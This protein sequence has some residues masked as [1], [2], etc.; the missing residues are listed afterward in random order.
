MLTK[1]QINLLIFLFFIF[2]GFR[3]L[4]LGM[5]PLMD[6][7]ESRY[8]EISREMVTQN[9]WITPLL[10]GKPFWA[11]PPLS[12]WAVNVS[13]KI[14]GINEFGA[15]F[16]S[17]V[18]CLFVLFFTYF[19]TYKITNKN[20]IIAFIS[21]F[22]LLTTTIF[23]VVSGGVMTDASLLFSVSLALVSFLLLIVTEKKIWNYPFF[24]GV[25]LS[26]LAKGPLGLVLIF[27]P[28][29]VWLLVFNEWK[30][31]FKKLYFFQ[32][33]F[34]VSITAIPWYILAEKNTPGFLNY[35]LLGEHVY[36]YIFK[37]W[38]GDLYGS[39]AGKHL[40]MI[41]LYAL[42]TF[43]PWI[44]W[45]SK[46]VFSFLK[47]EK[48]SGIFEFTKKT[49]KDKTISFLVFWMLSLF[50]FFTVSKNIL[51]TYTLPSVVPF[52]ILI[53]LFIERKILTQKF[54][55]RIFAITSSI[56][57]IVLFFSLIFVM[58]KEE[59]KSSQKFVI[60]KYQKNDSQIFYLFFTPPYSANFYSNGKANHI[61]NFKQL[62]LVLNSDSDRKNYFF[63]VKLNSLE[64]VEQNYKIEIL[65]KISD[66]VVLTIKSV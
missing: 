44:F 65:E 56:I 11:K 36:R 45:V 4:T 3:L 40:G 22:I 61:K 48:F 17:F 60:E 26:L 49:F 34:I 19:L 43:F 12:M 32:G 29:F 37:N 23:F 35:F 42:P 55:F 7:T 2:L 15:R 10:D 30:N 1:K 62:N 20:K 53:A 47:A 16:P 54:N 38:S 57:P 27:L 50:L 63:V 52:S 18:F 39:P 5:Y 41:W 9:S 64:Q 33:I 6:K 8:A 58:P 24:V 25:G 51:L 13:Y 66:Y 59:L 31:I 28:I 14:F 46:D 21:S